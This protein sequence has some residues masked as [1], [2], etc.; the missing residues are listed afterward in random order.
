[1]A[2]STEL[3]SAIL[4]LD[5][6]NR[7]DNRKLEVEGDR[8]GT[9][10]ITTDELD[11]AAIR[12]A[13]WA[14]YGFEAT[15]YRLDNGDLAIAFRGTDDAPDLVYGWPLGV[16]WAWA[17]QSGLT[18]DLYEAV[19]GHDIHDEAGIKPLVTG[20]SLGGGLAGYAS[21]LSG[22]TGY[23]WD[24]MPFGFAAYLQYAG[25]VFMVLLENLV[26]GEASLTEA[27]KATLQLVIDF[28]RPQLDE[29]VSDNLLPEF[30]DPVS[31][32]LDGIVGED[33]LLRAAA[34][35]LFENPFAVDLGP[36]V[37]DVVEALA[38]VL[39]AVTPD[40]IQSWGI[41]TPDFDDI[42]ATAT[43]SEILFR[44][45]DGSIPNA[46]GT[47]IQ[48]T[49]DYL[50]PY[51]GAFAPFVVAVGGVAKAA[52]DIIA[53]GITWAETQVDQQTLP[54]YGWTNLDEVQ[55]HSIAL[56]AILQYAEDG[57]RDDW[58]HGDIVET[59]LWT[60]FDQSTAEAAG[61]RTAVSTK[62]RLLDGGDYASIV[63]AAIAYSALDSGFRPYGDAAIRALFDDLNDLG[64]VQEKPNRDP[65]LDQFDFEVRYVTLGIPMLT[66]T[67]SIGG[68][69]ARIV[70]QYA[71]ALAIAGVTR[72]GVDEVF[73]EGGIVR[74]A[75]DGRTM[76]VDLSSVYWLDVLQTGSNSFGS[77]RMEPEDGANLLARYFEQ[78]AETD[79]DLL[80][81]LPGGQMD[82]AALDE[83]ASLGWQAGSWN[84][85][86]R[87]HV[88]TY[89]GV[90]DFTLQDRFYATEVPSGDETH[91]DVFIGTAEADR[92]TG[93]S[94]NDLLLADAGDD[95]VAGGAG[96]DFV[97]AGSGSDLI[98]DGL[99]ARTR[100][101]APQ[102]DPDVYVGEKI[103]QN[104]ADTF[105]SWLAV[106]PM[107]GD[108]TGDDR[109][110]YSVADPS[111]PESI[112][113]KGLVLQDITLGAFGDKEALRLTLLDRNS[114]LTAT[115]TLAHIDRVILSERADL[116]QVTP[117]MVE[118]PVWVDMRLGVPGGSFGK[119]D[120]DV[121][122]YAGAGKPIV[123]V[124]G[125]TQ[126]G[127]GDNGSLTGVG[128]LQLLSDIVGAA[129][130]VP[131]AASSLFDAFSANDPLRVTGA[132]RVE[133][134]AQDDIL[135]YGDISQFAGLITGWPAG[136]AYPHFGE[137]LGG[138]GNDVLVVRDARYVHDDEKID[139][140]VSDSPT[141]AG[142]L[143]LEVSGGA[144]EDRITIVGGEGA[145]AIGGPDRDFLF[146]WSHK[147]QLW[148]DAVDGSGGGE[149]IFW[150]SPGSF[151]MDAEPHDRLQMFGIP[152]TGGFGGADY[153]V[154]MDWVLPFVFYGLTGANQLLVNWFGFGGGDGED[155]LD[156]TMVVENFDFGTSQN[157]YGVSSLGDLGMS[158]RIYGAGDEMS[159]WNALWG[160]LMSYLQAL[161]V[162]AKSLQW[163]ASDDPLAIDLDGDGLE[164]SQVDFGVHF[165]LDGDGFA[166]RTGWVGP[167]DALLARDLDGNGSI[168]GIAELFGAPGVSG[169]S[170]LA[171]LDANRDGGVDAADP[172]WSTLRLWRDLDQDGQ[173]DA[174]EL[175]TPG[176]AGV[177]RIGVV[178]T[179]LGITVANGNQF[180]AE[181]AI[182]FGDGRRHD[183]VEVVFDTNPV[184]TRYLG[185]VGGAG[186]STSID[187]HGYGK[188]A[189]LRTSAANDFGVDA[190]VRSVAAAMTVGDIGLL[191]A[192]AQPVFEAWAG[193]FPAS[194]EL[195]PALVGADGTLVDRGIYVEDAVGGWW[196]R[197]S[198]RPVLGDDGV[199]IERPSLQQLLAQGP[200]I[201]PGSLWRLEPMWSPADRDGLPVHREAAPYLV[202]VEDGRATVLD[203]GV[204]VRDGGGSFWTLASGR[205]VTGADGQV[206]ARPQ[207]ADVLAM[208]AEPGQQWRVESFGEPAAP[209]PFEK[210]AVYYKGGQL[211]DYAVQVTDTAGSFFVWANQLRLALDYQ[212]RN[213]D[214][215]GFLLRN[216][217]LDL[218]DL[219]DADNTPD[220]FVRAEIVSGAQAA[221]AAAAYGIVFDPA[222]LTARVDGAGVLH[223]GAPLDET[224]DFMGALMEHY[225]FFSRAAAVRL[226]AQGGLTEFFR[227]LAYDPVADAWQPTSGR[228]LTPMFEAVFE[229][230][231]D[232]RDAAAAYLEQWGGVMEVIY[233]DLH[234]HSAGPKSQ[235]FVLQMV[236]GAYENVP[237]DA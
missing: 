202:H 110:D 65:W 67:T 211:T 27:G 149:D 154:A 134:T 227:D 92:I 53:Q 113:G 224:M 23:T 97:I 152:L 190:A 145:L 61:V 223:Y 164:T 59:F 24:H 230:A 166:Q 163:D 137:I 60:L 124:N 29:L 194:R 12:R 162:F 221:F 186:W 100:D 118:A 146:N 52:A 208:A 180:L 88:R 11:Q 156:T 106:L 169:F 189:S 229:R 38:P 138:A 17:G 76:A 122:S 151:I 96:R 35:H 176:A 55:R 136:D 30:P 6:Y 165:D 41:H 47:T 73:I 105:N 130:G 205:S 199:P 103:E 117:A 147:G 171:G 207:L 91:V 148:G 231:P 182:E 214:T 39:D 2:I 139:P 135:W 50:A 232:G 32:A 119:E 183:V 177:V 108:F 220:S 31:D 85:L 21:L 155:L 185:D 109:V 172:G 93:T 90:T 237:V 89:A 193:A 234:R 216:Y 15:S 198:G 4:A 153:G 81:F 95:T 196:Q 157:D 142:D 219:K 28:L 70:T 82:E 167:D 179:P 131:T 188:L 66:A 170:M 121:V 10:E 16:G 107:V 116:V 125:A 34:D 71:G 26:Q 46:I 37:D 80:S 68:I 42:R 218:D 112:A 222:V 217:A 13:E 200:S 160:H 58:Q 98:V 86:D 123:T 57:G 228:E 226:A 72:D 115:D 63:Q 44:L 195:A 128:Y 173:T 233:P 212:A 99:A 64:W 235:G 62:G 49:A 20:H 18:V 127:D 3:L 19:A 210:F 181:A 79:A 33:N 225:G 22:S 161:Q 178:P 43:E 206:L 209:F 201:G 1:M 14:D 132:E 78:S 114:G 203:H 5:A 168:D 48:W 191:R 36:L 236:V 84:I 45:R 141:A 197:A 204:P 51:T 184:D 74:V 213:G 144:G 25:K 187:L 215:A 133:L 104:A 129:I 102:N 83:L 56:A 8:I 111:D 143:R 7:G 101:G 87:I 150:W 94:A 120:Y 9:A 126:T 69:V 159:L 174:G 77:E 175:G 75:D 140:D 40:I 158:F 54:T 192:Q